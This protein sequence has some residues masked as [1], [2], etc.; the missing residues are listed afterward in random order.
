MVYR[1]G[2]R[3]ENVYFIKSGEFEVYK[4]IFVKDPNPIKGIEDFN[5]I[6]RNRDKKLTEKMIPL[7]II[8]TSNYFGGEE[9][10]LQTSSRAFTIK[11]S[12]LTSEVIYIDRGVNAIEKI[13]DKNF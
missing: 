4:K 7:T 2:D 8:G 3:A 9:S 12:S 1:E 13:N 6:Q 11:C 5:Q 10:V